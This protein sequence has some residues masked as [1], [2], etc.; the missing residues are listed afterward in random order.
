MPVI[1]VVTKCEGIRAQL[2][3]KLMKDGLDR[4][5]ARANATPEAQ[6]PMLT[7]FCNKLKE[8]SRP[9]TQIVQLSST[10]CAT[11]PVTDS[12]LTGRHAPA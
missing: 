9:G 3:A 4:R 8:A 2:I 6:V 1:V 11:I 5:A 7:E 10:P 12:N